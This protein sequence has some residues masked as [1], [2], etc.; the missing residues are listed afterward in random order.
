MATQRTINN[1]LVVVGMC[2]SG[3][4]AVAEALRG[5]G[6]GGGRFWA[7]TMDEL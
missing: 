2:G 1:A 3:K 7:I 4:S 6:W 5:K